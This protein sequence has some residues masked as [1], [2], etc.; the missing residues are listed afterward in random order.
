LKFL[1]RA[2]KFLQE[3]GTEPAAR[4]QSF[5]VACAGG[6]RVRGERTEGYQ[7]LRCPVCGEGV[8]VL[9]YSPLPEPVAPDGLPEP[10][11]VASLARDVWVDEGPIELTNP[12]RG[13]VE[14]DVDPSGP[15]VA[16]IVW[17]DAP[18]AGAPPPRVAA[19][20][21]VA[22]EDLAAA[23]IDAARR[24]ES[25]APRRTERGAV[26]RLPQ[27]GP[28]RAG[29]AP[30]D[31][32]G[33]DARPARE[34][35]GGSGTARVA[36]MRPGAA[37]APAQVAVE[38]R[39]RTRRGPSVGLIFFLLTLLIGGTVGWRVWMS[40]RAHYPLT[41]ERG[42]TE[43]IPALEE[44]DFD[45][46]HQLLS[47]AR[48]AV[49][50]LGGNVT[51]AEEIRQAAAEA[52]IFVDLCPTSLE[53]LLA[54]AGRGSNLEAWASRFDALYKGRWFLFDTLIAATPE[55]SESGAYEIAYVVVPPGEASR[56]SA[57]GLP[58]P[59]RYARIDLAG[60]EAIEQAGGLKRDAH[61]TFA[62]K[63]RSIDY[64]AGRKHWMVRLEPKSGVFITHQRALLALGLKDPV[65]VDVP[66][67]DQP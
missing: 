6:H 5:N 34:S 17:D 2:K 19:S 18:A 7:A 36:R 30:S 54:E 56:F 21:Q 64:D 22:P 43:G 61:V 20:T 66:R 47:A 55:D 50:A 23:E 33:P 35:T 8:F 15:G 58:E 24:A 48:S 29:R 14:V 37:E 62:A 46:A 52:A 31:G 4:T 67:E 51:D 26:A 45:R 42:K 27:A 41:I 57:S 60:F 9:P 59:E 63:L 44:G 1:G 3:L 13:A 25:A 65:M 38:P 16:D 49:D 28:N 53:E 10:R 39:P 11:G 32:R 12:A 40:R